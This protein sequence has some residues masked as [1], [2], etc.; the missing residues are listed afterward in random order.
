MLL[1]HAR[2]NRSRTFL[3]M[4]DVPVILVIELQLLPEQMGSRS[5]VAST[6]W[7]YYIVGPGHEASFEPF[8]TLL[9]DRLKGHEAW[10]VGQTIPHDCNLVSSELGRRAK[11]NVLHLARFPPATG[12][13]PTEYI[14]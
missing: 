7:C 8:A 14:V 5:T 9:R 13:N 2:T 3:Q 1:P 10:S 12:E 4:I 6:P 11:S